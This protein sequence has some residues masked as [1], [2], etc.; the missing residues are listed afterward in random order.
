MAED[1]ATASASS[2]SPSSSSSSSSASSSSS[3]ASSS[4]SSSSSAA[5]TA[6]SSGAGDAL[7]VDYEKDDN[8]GDDADGSARASKRLRSEP[9]EGGDA[10]G[11]AAAALP[12]HGPVRFR[13]VALSAATG[14]FELGSLTPPRSDLG[15][16]AGAEG[17]AGAGA[18]AG[19]DADAVAA[20]AGAEDEADAAALD[21]EFAAQLRA[22]RAALPARARW[23]V[24]PTLAVFGPGGLSPRGGALLAALK[25]D[26]PLATPLALW[27]AR[28]VL[29][30]TVSL[31]HPFHAEAA[32]KLAFLPMGRGR[33]AP[34][35]FDAAPL[36]VEA[37][38]TQA[39][40]LPGPPRPLGA[41]YMT[42]LTVALFQDER[43]ERDDRL[44]RLRREAGAGAGAAAAA[45]AAAPLAVSV[46]LELCCRV[47][48]KYL[49]LL[50]DCV[51][52]RLAAW[53]AAHCAALGFALPLD[54]GWANREWLAAVAAAAPHDPQRRFAQAV[55]RRVFAY[56]DASASHARLRAAL[57]G[58]EAAAAAPGAYARLVAAKITEAAASPFLPAA[59]AAAAPAAA[60]AA[61][62]PADAAAPAPAPADGEAEMT[63]SAAPAPAPAPTPAP[64]PAPAPAPRAPP[65]APVLA[66]A[67]SI[68]Q[69]IEARADDA[70]MTAWLAPGGEGVAA[71]EAAGGAGG[72]PLP[73]LPPALVLRV[74]AHCLF[75]RA[76]DNTRNAYTL[77]R[78]YRALLLS[79]LGAAGDARAHAILGA[80]ARVW[81]AAP[82]V[83]PAVAE[84]AADVGV[85]S[86]AQ[87][88]AFAI[89]GAE[90]GA[91]DAPAALLGGVCD[92]SN[93][94]ICEE[95]D[96]DADANDG[97]GAGAGA[98]AP[99]VRR[100][101]RR[102]FDFRTWE[103]LDASCLD[104]AAAAAHAAGVTVALARGAAVYD[105]KEEPLSP[106]AAAQREAPF[107]A[108]ARAAARAL[109]DALA[110]AFAAGARAAV[111]LQDAADAD[112]RAAGA[113]AP[114][115]AEALR[116]V[117]SRL[118]DAARRHG[119]V[120]AGS[121]R[122]RAALARVAAA[123]PAGAHAPLRALL[124]SAAAGDYARVAT[125]AAPPALLRDREFVEPFAS[126]A[127]LADE[128]GE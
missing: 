91:G 5:A 51:A 82:H 47:L 35:A 75:L 60:P 16:E 99:R 42:A 87:L 1:E 120:L 65:S 66:L 4:S 109:V 63:D 68:R 58:A 25:L 71:A 126:A 98:L 21:A 111:E 119:E 84:A 2:S 92:D 22:R 89:G 86:F 70:A 8:D 108:A 78:R 107:V 57:A 30:D 77:L 52:D 73:P 36:A 117:L 90:A 53:V 33:G 10:P 96:A 56:V 124:L 106:A 38:L 41:A 34:R 54:G 26:S 23:F 88:A 93:G 64:A 50:D 94:A 83:F 45:A 27:A 125:P 67:A 102:V 11:A 76:K 31:F 55:T 112:A 104:R 121:A 49:P 20:A 6:A 113:H 80:A 74:F 48:F 15:A 43:R 72:E 28:E 12:R 101:L 46:A 105:P 24:R 79:G 116:V 9:A 69:R 81:A 100:L 118:R 39:L 95:A 29:H 85:V 123:L 14:E 128:E 7:D 97:A 3:S 103:L 127:Q 32:A 18:G 62:A 40:W 122:A 61:A 37:A 19:A 110:A 115:L 59:P 114:A 17:G 13:L 44:R